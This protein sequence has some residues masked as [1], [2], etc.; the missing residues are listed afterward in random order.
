[1]RDK[2]SLSENSI[3]KDIHGLEEKVSNKLDIQQKWIAEKYEWIE[4]EYNCLKENFNKIA[5][6]RISIL[7]GIIVIIIL[8]IISFFV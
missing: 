2:I 6:I 5:K 4:K 3:S 1:M 7:C 8:Q